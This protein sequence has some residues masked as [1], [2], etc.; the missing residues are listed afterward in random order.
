L[1]NAPASFQRFMEGC[2]EGLRDDICLPYL[3]DIIVFSKN[4]EEHIDHLITVL[5]RFRAHGLN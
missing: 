5:Q 4:F 2:L 1:T 3:D